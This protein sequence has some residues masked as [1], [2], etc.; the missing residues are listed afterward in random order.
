MLSGLHIGQMFILDPTG[1]QVVGRSQH[2][3]IQLA[4]VDISRMHIAIAP[5]RD[6]RFWLEDLG[7]RNGT[8][9]NGERIG[10]RPL[11]DGDKIQLGR[12][13]M[14]RF[15]YVDDFDES[16]QRLMY[17][18][19]LR[20][21]LTRSFNR[22]YFTERLHAEFH[23]ARRH[24]TALSL[25]LLDL[26][27]FKRV[28]DANGHVA[29]DYVLTRFAETMQKNMRN[30]DVFARFGGEEF[31][32]ISRSISAKG[33]FR[34]AERLRIMVEKTDIYYDKTRIA[35]TMSIGIGSLPDLDVKSPLELVEAADRALYIAKK[36][37]RNQVRLYNPDED[38]ESDGH[39]SDGCGTAKPSDD[40]QP[41]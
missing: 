8:F 22:R 20:D 18:S 7:S 29:G 6:G 38:R 9:C 17:N 25:L 1:R 37:G 32:I 39:E 41:F 5:G 24:D 15:T 2:A 26:D 35:L 31:A 30:E 12:N 19:A 16:F 10:K 28:N 13:T 3:H 36:R 33:A 34:L 21:G 14:L 27:H 40:T 23:F 4:D 11:D